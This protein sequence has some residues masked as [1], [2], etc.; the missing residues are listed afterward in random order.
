MRP[1]TKIF[2][3]VAILL[4]IF[5]CRTNTVKDRETIIRTEHEFAEMAGEKGLSDEF[6][7]PAIYSF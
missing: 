1:L 5:S 3:T 2:A 7:L 4:I 6:F